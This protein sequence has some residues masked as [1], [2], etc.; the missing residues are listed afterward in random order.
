MAKTIV[1]DKFEN[2]DFD[3]FSAITAL[4]KKDYGYYDRLTVE[5]QQKF[6]PYMLIIWFSCIKASRD[7]QGYYLLSTEY[8][9]NKFMFNEHVQ[10]NPKLQWLM[11][12]SA[13]PG[14]GKQFHQYLPHI[15]ESI[16]KLREV[17]KVKDIQEYYKKVYPKLNADDLGELCQAFVTEQKRKVYFAK[18][19]PQLKFEDISV[20]SQL[21]SEEEIKKYEHD[22][23]N[24]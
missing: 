2:V 11:L 18:K 23:G 19:F 22:S 13:S 6:V 12:C 17:A 8:H 9:A 3:L 15:K 1:D 21:V 24:E 14:I 5:Q 10:K 7:L 16:S 20:L 4:D